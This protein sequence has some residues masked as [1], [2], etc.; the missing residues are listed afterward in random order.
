MNDNFVK[1]LFRYHSN[2]L[3]KVVAETMWAIEID[4][5]KGIYQLDSIPFYG[6]GIA[7]EDK[8]FAVYDENEGMLSYQGI[9]E[10]SGNSIVLVIVVDQNLDKEVLRAE[11]RA[12]NCASEGLNDRYFSMEILKGT[13]YTPI[14]AKLDA[15]QADNR[16]NYA[17]PC[18]SEKHQ[19]DLKATT[20]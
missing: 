14:K 11:F 20:L 15:Y 5:S 18:L 10:H 2:V 4:K 9:T 13:N 16:I 8:F 19:T 17:E 12:L 1:V 3:D 6:V 7:P